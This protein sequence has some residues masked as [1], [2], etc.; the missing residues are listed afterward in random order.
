VI[1]IYGGGGAVNG[2]NR[3]ETDG[4]GSLIGAVLWHD[5]I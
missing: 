1:E 4:N 2:L 3:N 5:M